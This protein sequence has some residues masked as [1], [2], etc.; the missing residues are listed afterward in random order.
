MRYELQILKK[1]RPIDIKKRN[2]STRVSFEAIREVAI[3]ENMK[4]KEN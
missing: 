2:G 1:F 4:R 3:T